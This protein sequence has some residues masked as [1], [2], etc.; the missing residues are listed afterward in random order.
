MSASAGFKKTIKSV[1]QLC[2][3]IQ[4]RSLQENPESTVKFIEEFAITSHIQVRRDPNGVV[5]NQSQLQQVAAVVETL[6]QQVMAVEQP[7]AVPQPQ[8]AVAAAKKKGKKNKGTPVPVELVKKDDQYML[9]IGAATHGSARQLPEPQSSKTDEYRLV[10]G[11]NSHKRLMSKLQNECNGVV[12]SSLGRVLA[13]PPPAFTECL[14]KD[15]NK[16]MAENFYDVYRVDDSTIVTLYYWD[17]K[18]AIASSKGYDVSTLRWI[19]KRT[20]AEV[21]YDLAV[22]LYPGFVEATGISL[23]SGRLSF[24]NVLE[25]GKSYTIG[26][27][28][29]DFHPLKADAEN[30]KVLAIADLETLQFVNDARLP[31]IGFQERILESFASLDAIKAANHDALASAVTAVDSYFETGAIA[32]FNYGYILRAKDRSESVLIAS[33][34]L[35]TMRKIYAAPPRELSSELRP[36]NRFEY[37]VARAYLTMTDKY[38]FISLF[39]DW[40]PR[41]DAYDELIENIC[42]T[43]G[44]V[45]MDTKKNGF[46]A[47]SKNRESSILSPTMAISSM[48]HTRMVESRMLTSN[49]VIS[50]EIIKDFICDPHYSYVYMCRVLKS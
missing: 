3:E 6:L 41:F 19:G 45:I 18:W 4:A 27:R 26:F 23:E 42:S 30:L 22:R 14:S 11:I 39:K 2:G 9:S 29:H 37:S 49:G 38:D 34:L 10:L 47:L 1:A 43:I 13:Y 48:L 25:V 16:K 35:A 24:K 46:P 36:E 31:F 28:H 17:T 50:P 44:Q 33:N 32:N 20:Y 7:V 40:K 5:K 15:V 21:I 12:I 8:V